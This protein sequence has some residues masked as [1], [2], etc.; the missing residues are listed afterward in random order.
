MQ[1]RS[2]CGCFSWSEH[3]NDGFQPCGDYPDCERGR[4]MARLT[5][6]NERRQKRREANTRRDEQ[7]RKRALAKLTP[8][9]RRVLGVR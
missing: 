2:T 9:Q 5:L 3:Y 4:E 8:A 7:T 6:E 1:W